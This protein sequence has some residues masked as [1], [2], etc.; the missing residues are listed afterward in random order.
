MTVKGNQAFKA[1]SVSE[2]EESEGSF[3]YLGSLT[4]R[5]IAD[6]P[7]GDLLI[8]VAYSS[9]N[10]KDAL[11]A[12]GN[13]AV[14]R[15]YPHTPGIDAAGVVVES[16]VE[17]FK[18]GDEVVV[19]GFDLGMETPGGFGQFIRVPV[20]WAVRLPAGLTLEDSMIIGTAGF[21]AALCV[22]KLLTNGL[23][24]EYGP[25]LVTGASGGVG[26]F[27]VALLSQLGFEVTAMSGSAEAAEFLKELGATEIIDREHFAEAG[28]RAMLSERWAGALDVVGGD[29]LFNV[30]KSLRYGG[31]V[32]CC[33][34]V[35]APSFHATVLPFILRGVNLLGVDSVNLP[36]A[37]R[38][39]V[40]QRLGEEWKLASLARLRQPISRADL[41]SAV[42][43]VLQG[44]SIGRL[45]LDHAAEP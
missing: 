12:T 41:E 5:R 40:W 24:P 15:H 44:R 30:I 27:A 2:I 23:A 31:S 21:T 43:Q 33:G 17:A 28:K 9:I 16:G 25:V 37:Q 19:T 42:Q 32:A 35:A 22:D 45:V 39:P 26:S 7:A 3:K 13:K 38:L 10:Y 8:Q 11:S 29:T 6:L 20:D 18:P 14:T 36:M 1:F 4:E 34:L